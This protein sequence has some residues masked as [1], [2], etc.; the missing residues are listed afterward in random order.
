VYLLFY[1]VLFFLL[2]LC[3]PLLLKLC[4][5]LPRHQFSIS[6]NLFW[7]RFALSLKSRSSGSFSFSNQQLIEMTFSA[8]KFPFFFLFFFAALD[9]TNRFS[10]VSFLTHAHT[11]PF[12]RFPN[13]LLTINTYSL[14]LLPRFFKKRKR[15]IFFSPLLF[16]RRTFP[17]TPTNA[18]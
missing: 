9:Y 13:C 15:N 18:P 6:I 3:I 11:P 14:F 16:P 2:L 1:A 17:F 5:P 12:Y 7:K 10:F 8:P 4:H